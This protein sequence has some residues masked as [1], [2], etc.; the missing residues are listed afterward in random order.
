MQ[1]FLHFETEFFIDVL[2][3]LA[4]A[5]MSRATL[6]VKSAHRLSHLLCNLL[7]CKNHFGNVLSNL[8]IFNFHFQNCRTVLSSCGLPCPKCRTVLRF[9]FSLSQN[10]RTVLSSLQL[11]CPNCRTVVSLGR[12]IPAAGLRPPNPGFGALLRS[13]TFLLHSLLQPGHFWL[14]QLPGAFTPPDHGV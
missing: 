14:P 3:T 5:F 10:C 8:F 6:V 13:L 4:T 12:S 9:R 1:C 11:P 7:I 2:S